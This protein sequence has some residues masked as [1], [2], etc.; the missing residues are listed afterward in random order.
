MFRHFCHQLEIE[1]FKCWHLTP[2]EGIY[3]RAFTRNETLPP[4][5]LGNDTYFHFR[6]N[7]AFVLTKILQGRPSWKHLI[8][9]Q[10]NVPGSHQTQLHLYESLQKN[11]EFLSSTFSSLIEV[12]PSKA[13]ASTDVMTLLPMS[14]KKTSV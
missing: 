1:A 4:N 10:R 6:G 14:Y 7:D 3:F 12:K 13:K 2:N 11:V 8:M 9:L 5:L